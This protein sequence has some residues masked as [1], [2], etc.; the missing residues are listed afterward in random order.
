MAIY[1]TALLALCLL[2]GSIVGRLL[3]MV[4]GIDANVGGVGIAM[5]LLIFASDWLKRRGRLKPVTEQGVLF[6]S[7]IYIPVVVA[8]AAGQNV[9]AALEGGLAAFLAGTLAVVVCLG[10][11]PV[12]SRI[13]GPPAPLPGSGAGDDD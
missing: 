1:G 7:S 13:G 10:M 3:G 4:V 12:L 8:M 2:I 6:W 9:V 11:V 5:L